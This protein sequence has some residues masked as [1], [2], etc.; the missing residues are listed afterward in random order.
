VFLTSFSLIACW[1]L[2]W[3]LLKSH[4]SQLG[5][6]THVALLSWITGDEVLSA[7]S[8][9]SLEFLKPHMI[10]YLGRKEAVLYFNTEWAEAALAETGKCVGKPL[11]NPLAIGTVLRLLRFLENDL[12]DRWLNDLLSLMKANRKCVN[13]L[14][15]LS[16]WQTCLFPLLSETLELVSSHPTT[17]GDGTAIDLLDPKE[18]PMSLDALHKRLDLCL[19]LYSSLLGHLLRSGGDHVS[20]IGRIN[21]RCSAVAQFGF[22]SFAG[23]GGC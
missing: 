11:R 20:I 10:S 6:M 8:L 22:Y 2:L 17:S 15:S 19:Q 4:R 21:L 18:Y 9:A 13:V 5:E 23:T 7:T 3:H 12:K 14:A 16:E 1:Q